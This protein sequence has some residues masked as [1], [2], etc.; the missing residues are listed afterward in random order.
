MD[1]KSLRAQ[2]T[3]QHE[4]RVK[5]RRG[6]SPSDEAAD[7]A[8][9]KKA[10]AEHDTQLHGGKHTKLHLKDGGCADGGRSMRRMDRPGRASGGKAGGKKAHTNVNVIVAG[11]GED[12]PVPVPVPAAGGAPPP[13]P[14]MPPPGAMGPGGPPMMPPPGAGMPPGLAGPRP[15]MGPPGMPM[16]ARGGSVSDAAEAHGKELAEHLDAGAAGGLGRLEKSK[17]K[18]PNELAAGD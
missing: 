18:I 2:A 13:H 5:E 1:H 7:V 12:R 3:A 11:K 16:R 15:P 4:S 10:F 17:M 9:V 6:E 8:R 14:P